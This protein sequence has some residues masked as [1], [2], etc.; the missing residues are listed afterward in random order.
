MKK[1]GF[2]IGFHIKS[3]G[4]VL[5]R[6]VLLILWVTEEVFMFFTPKR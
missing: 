1:I 6:P 4:L 5:E 3:F 2:E